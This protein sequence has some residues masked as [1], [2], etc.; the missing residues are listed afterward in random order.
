MYSYHDYPKYSDSE[1]ADFAL[2]K[3]IKPTNL[4]IKMQLASMW[5]ISC[6]IQ[7]LVQKHGQHKMQWSML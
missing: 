5:S 6:N 1:N 7:H 2:F 3:L 4:D